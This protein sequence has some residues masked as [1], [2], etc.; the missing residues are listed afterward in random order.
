MRFRRRVAG[1]AVALACATAVVAASPAAARTYLLSGTQVP[2]DEAN[3]YFLNYGGLLGVWQITAFTPQATSPLFH[4]TGTEE[5]HGCL[6]LNHDGYCYQE[7]TGTLKFTFDFWAKFAAD[8]AEVWGACVHPIVSGA[9]GF[10]GADGIVTMIDNSTPHGL[11]T[12]WQG[13]LILPDTAGAARQARAGRH[14][15]SARA[16]LRHWRQ[17]HAHTTA[18]P[19][20]FCG[21]A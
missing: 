20:G 7:P 6:N 4:A 10:A 15:M 11:H 18:V 5:F 16:I 21:G 19:R 8:G 1:I 12:R 17:R 9:G 14:R 13:V 2:V 3:G